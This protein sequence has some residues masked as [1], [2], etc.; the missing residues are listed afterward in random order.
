MCLSA[1]TPI[2]YSVA[3]CAAALRCVGWEASGSLFNAMT[4]DQHFIFKLT[5]AGEI[6]PGH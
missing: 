5:T 6:Q 4:D 3:R 2:G 1:L